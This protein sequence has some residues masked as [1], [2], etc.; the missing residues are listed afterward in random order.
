MAETV[1]SDH[2]SSSKG[3]P[4]IERDVDNVKF[5]LSLGFSKSTVAGVLGIS[6]KNLYNRIALPNPDDVRKK[7]S[8]ITE[9]Q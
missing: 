8:A 7:H 1:L 4:S 3:R 9:A 5:L 2:D 6:R